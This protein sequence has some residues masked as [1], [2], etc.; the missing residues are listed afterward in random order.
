[1]ATTT[2]NGAGSKNRDSYLLSA[3]WIS[4]T[5]GI[6]GG[7]FIANGTAP[8]VVTGIRVFLGGRGGSRTGTLSFGS[9][10]GF[11]VGPAGSSYWALDMN[12]V[13]VPGGSL[14]TLRLDVD[15]AFNFGRN[16]T[17]GPGITSSSG[18]FAGTIAGDFDYALGPSEPR[19]VFWD[20]ITTNSMRVDFFAPLTDGG[21]PLIRYVVDVF[22]DSDGAL[23]ATFGT[24]TGQ[25]VV[26]GLQPATRYRARVTAQ[27]AVTNLAGSTGPWSAWAYA[28][29]LS[30]GEAHNGTAWVPAISEAFNGTAWVPATSEVFDG[31]TWRAPS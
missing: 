16:D 24:V 22:R 10:T 30:G 28:T 3:G 12:D 25:N 11:A 8:V 15:G 27:T 26:T 31:A 29:T 6:P 19:G 1:M 18:T 23:V 4:C 20:A 2:I 21:F 7:R 13:L 14:Q 9:A 17:I 5:V